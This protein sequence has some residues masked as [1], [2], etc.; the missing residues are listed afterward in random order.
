MQTELCSTSDGRTSS[1]VEHVAPVVQRNR[2]FWRKTPKE[3]E[4]DDDDDDDDDDFC[5]RVT[6]F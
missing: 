5:K 6:Y 3:E 2:E 4:T 1:S